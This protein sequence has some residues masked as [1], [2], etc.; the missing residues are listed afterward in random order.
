VFGES[1]ANSTGLLGSQIEGQIL[2]VLVE[3]TELSALVGVNNSK[4]TS[5]RL[6]EIVTS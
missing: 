1:S 4:D 2:L 5:N 3:E 6:A